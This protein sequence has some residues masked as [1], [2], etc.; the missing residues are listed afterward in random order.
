MRVNR[1]ILWRTDW[2]STSSAHTCP[3]AFSVCFLYQNQTK[4][5]FFLRTSSLLLR[6]A[7]LHTLH[8]WLPSSS[9]SSCSV[10]HPPTGHSGRG[11]CY[12]NAPVNGSD[13]EWLGVNGCGLK[14]IM[15][16]C[17]SIW[18]HSAV[19]GWQGLAGDCQSVHTGSSG[20]EGGGGGVPPHTT[21]HRWEFQK[22][23]RQT[24]KS[25]HLWN[26]RLLFQPQRQVVCHRHCQPLFP[27][28][29]EGCCFVHF[30][31]FS[32]SRWTKSGVILNFNT[33]L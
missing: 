24:W 7:A 1:V 21:G 31:I 12:V 16:N 23:R 2:T 4:L 17:L 14:Q 5:W 18:R 32:T 25:K 29:E 22:P 13:W 8:P 33:P 15:F 9:S 28:F 6:S 3:F 30:S 20:G 10:S 19:K 27:P 11:D 26:V